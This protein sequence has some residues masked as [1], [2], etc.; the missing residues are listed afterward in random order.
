MEDPVLNRNLE[1]IKEL[2]TRW[3]QFHDFVNMAMQQGPSKITPQAELKF[4]E[5]KSRIAMLHDGFMGGVKADVKTAQNII[6]IVADCIMLKR[7]AVATDAEKQK[8]EFDWNECFMLLNE[9]VST[10]EEEKKKLAGINE[11]AYKA[12]KRREIMKARIHNFL[13]SP[14]LKWFVVIFGTIGGLI[15]VQVFYGYGK[16]YTDIS[17]TKGAYKSIVGTVWRPFISPDLEYHDYE[18]VEFNEKATIPEEKDANLKEN[19]FTSRIMASIGFTADVADEAKKLFND[20]KDKTFFVRQSNL[21]NCAFFGFVLNSTADAKKFIDLQKQGIAKLDAAR[22]Q[23]VK[24]E[25]YVRRR[26]N[27]VAIGIGQHPLRAGWVI[28]H[29]GLKEKNGQGNEIAKP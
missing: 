17:F 10:L 2:Q 4:L 3:N 19:D 29:W 24:D 12:A 27:L 9:T 20:R 26:A 23:K 5:L 7:S 1:E 6:Q 18:E 25:T 28:D 21:G 11:R 15:A 16:F 13:H 22:Q 8:F 14:L